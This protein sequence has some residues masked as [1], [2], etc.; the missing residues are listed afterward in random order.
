MC[1]AEN[2][3]HR[4]LIKVPLF[5]QFSHNVVVMLWNH[6]DQFLYHKST[7][8]PSAINLSNQGCGV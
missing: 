3:S 7:F 1:I 8:Y 2:L 4:L 6:I 5:G